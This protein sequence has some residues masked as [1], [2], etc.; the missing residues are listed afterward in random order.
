[1]KFKEWLNEDKFGLDSMGDKQMIRE[2][3]N[4]ENNAINLYEI[5]ANKT[6]NGK[7]REVM[8]HVAR[9]EKVHI[10]EFE[11]LLEMIDPQYKPASEEGEEELEDRGIKD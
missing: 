4:E 11:E 2:A 9:E 10:G 1:M 8:L 7:V 5:M 3:I 6:R